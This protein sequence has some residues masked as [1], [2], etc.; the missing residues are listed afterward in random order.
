MPLRGH[1]VN[2]A[3]PP[4]AP[5]LHR[6]L[7][8]NVPNLNVPV[9]AHAALRAEDTDAVALHDLYL[10]LG[11]EPAARY[12]AYQELLASEA[13]REPLSLA[14][15]Y[16]LGSSRFIGRMESRF[17]S[18]GGLILVGPTRGSRQRPK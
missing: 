18:R 5:S 10:E 2:P 4:L 16:F 7:N 17:A 9:S 1:R 12:R 15:A 6:S 11:A 13:A 14:T 8:L 3:L